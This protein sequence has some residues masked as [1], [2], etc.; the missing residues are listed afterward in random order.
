MFVLLYGENKICLNYRTG[1]YFKSRV[2]GAFVSICA[3]HSYIGILGC[4]L[5]S[6]IAC[7]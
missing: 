6:H 4:A 5:Q 7:V 1:K 2:T 3:G